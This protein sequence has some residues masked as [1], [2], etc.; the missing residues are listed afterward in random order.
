MGYD[1][2]GFDFEDDERDSKSPKELRDAQRAAAKRAKELEVQV[3]Q[4]SKQL[5]DR[6][7]KDVLEDKGLR[8]GLARVI[9]K[10][11][12]DATDPVAIEA[13]LNDPANQEDFAFSVAA[14]DDGS[15]N[16]SDDDAGSDEE[17]DTE[18][19]AEFTRMQAASNGALPPNKYV[20]A[21]AQIKKAGATGGVDGSLPEIQAALDR[22]V[23]QAK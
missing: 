10:D 22:A 13:W 9:S 19:A 7:L 5:A 14:G 1:N 16:D 11:G 3:Q 4:L 12:V 2:D 17:Q 21:E 23:K 20:E 8:P 18:T 15:S 6:N